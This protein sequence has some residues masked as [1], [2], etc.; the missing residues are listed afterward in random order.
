MSEIETPVVACS[1]CG[2][3][4]TSFQPNC[5]NCGGPIAPPPGEHAGS[6]PPPA[7]RELPSGYMRRQLLKSPL[8]IMGAIFSLIGVPFTIIYP[9]IGISTGELLFLLIGGCF[10]ITGIIMVVFSM[11]TLRKKLQAFEFG[12]A[13]IGKVVEVYRDTSIKVN[14]R[15]PWAIVYEFDVQGRLYEGT[16]RSWEYSAQKR[17]PG[18]PLHVL[19]MKEEPEHNT[20]Y[21]PV[22]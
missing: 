22:K 7:P 12:E 14:G 21:P 9:I 3:N 18:Q 20:I 13:V 5:R 15:S 17:K 8:L 19:Y 16:V 11:R 6:L 2:T 4:Y 1:W 10:S